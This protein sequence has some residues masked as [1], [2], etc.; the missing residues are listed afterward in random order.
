MVGFLDDS[1]P[2][3]DPVPADLARQAAVF[4]LRAAV[5][6]DLDA[7]RLRLRR[8]LV[9][10]HGQLHPDHLR[11]RI[12][13]QRLVDDR[14]HGVDARKDVDHVDRHRHVGKPGIGHAAENFL[15]GMA[16][17]DR[18]DVVPLVDQVFRHEE[19]RPHVVGRGADD[20][21]RL[22]RVEDAGDVG[23]VVGIVVHAGSD[24]Y[25]LP[26]RSESPDCGRPPRDCLPDRKNSRTSR[27]RRRGPPA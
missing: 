13:R 6:H 19:A 26:R 21:D 18:I 7:G 2:A 22:H 16:R 4:D 14:R 15:A 12:E 24:Q 25:V 9:V 17:I 27:P 23:V 20:R 3:V 8:R 11:Q 5:H 1:T 10:A